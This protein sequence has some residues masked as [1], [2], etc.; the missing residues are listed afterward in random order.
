MF[1]ENYL[2]YCCLSDMPGMPMT[3]GQ[4]PPSQYG[5]GGGPPMGP[6][7][8]TMYGWNAPGSSQ[9]QGLMS[10]G[11]IPT[12]GVTLLAPFLNPGD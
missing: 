3:G 8:N 6:P 9:N 4:N 12:V 7:H 1:M 10:Q 2:F 5:Y 11:N